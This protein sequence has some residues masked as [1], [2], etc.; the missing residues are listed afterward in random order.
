MA[1]MLAID[2]DEV[3][4]RF[5]LARSE[6]GRLRISSA[7][8]SPIPPD[9]T[10]EA[11]NVAQAIQAALSGRKLGRCTV[12]VGLGR[13][14]LEFLTLTLP[15][16]KEAELPDL[17]AHAILRQSPHLSDGA[18]VDFLSLNDIP[19]EPRVVSAAVCPAGRI[20]R[21]VS[22]CQ[23][24]GLRTDRILVRP[25]ALAALLRREESLPSSSLIVCH[26]AD[27]IDFAVVSNGRVHYARTVKLPKRADEE[28]VRERL[29][30][31]IH[32]TVLVAS[33]SQAGGQTIQQ[34]YMFGQADE[35]V[36][37]LL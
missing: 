23:G 30:A 22:C 36:V 21:I 24:A 31:E 5:V 16:A 14:D 17:V 20:E 13:A 26:V 19:T 11:S 28:S 7:G 1:Q 10:S 4:V 3:E 35:L 18:T 15:P 12:L 32:R 6:G 2:W 27:E 8:T 29:L 37:M 25:Y 33:Q 34:I 9:E